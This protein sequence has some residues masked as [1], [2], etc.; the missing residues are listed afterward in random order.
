VRRKDDDLRAG[1]GGQRG[2][3]MH[4]RWVK[5]KQRASGARAGDDEGSLT[6]ASEPGTPS[7]D[8]HRSLEPGMSALSIESGEEDGVDAPVRPPL[9]P[10]LAGSSSSGSH[11]S[12]DSSLLR[13]HF[14][15]RYFILK[16]LT[17][18]RTSLALFNSF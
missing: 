9:R 13:Q 4:T 1:V 6:S 12:T 16:S 10:R 14:P 7:S 8:S 11:A 2:I 15:Q 17:R 3:G 18:V 5:A